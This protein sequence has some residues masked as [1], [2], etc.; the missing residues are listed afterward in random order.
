MKTFK[1]FQEGIKTKLAIG[2]LMALPFAMQKIKDKFDPVGNKR[3]EY[4]LDKNLERLSK[5]GDSPNA[6]DMLNIPRDYKITPEQKE[7]YGFK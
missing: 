4:Q 1:Q 2:G 6:R 7:K 3:K 5:T